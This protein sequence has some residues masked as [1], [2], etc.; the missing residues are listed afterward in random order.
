M[1]FPSVYFAALYVTLFFIVVTCFFTRHFHSSFTV[2][3]HIKLR[4]GM[5]RQR[6]VCTKYLI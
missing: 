1:F 4:P 2:Y 3:M 5:L 6:Y